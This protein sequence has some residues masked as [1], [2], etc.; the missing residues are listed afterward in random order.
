MNK[1][2][3]IIFIKLLW[4]IAALFAIYIFSWLN[5]IYNFLFNDLFRSHFLVF[6][7]SN[8]ATV[9]ILFIYSKELLL[10]YNTPSYKSNLKWLIIFT[11]L[12][13]IL[14]FLQYKIFLMLFLDFRTWQSSISILIILT[15]YIG[16]V[17]NRFFK[18]KE[19]TKE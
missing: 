19:L 15:S 10:G 8:L 7:L 3:L 1:S 5:F 4:I 17:L 9:S 2:T 6:I 18:L 12:I 11:L 13:I 16:I 14:I